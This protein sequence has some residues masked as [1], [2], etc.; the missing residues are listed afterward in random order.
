MLASPLLPSF[1]DTYRPSKSSR[2][3]NT[4]IIIVIICSLLRVFH[5]SVSWWFHTGVWVT[6]TS[7]Q[8][9]MTLLSILADLN[10]A[11]VWMVSTRPV[12]SKYSSPCT[13]SLVTLPR[14][15]ITIGIIV[16]FM[17]HSFFNS[18]AKLRYLSLF[19]HSFIFTLWSAGT[20]KST[21]LHVLFFVVEYYKIWS[22]GQ[23]LVIRLYLKIPEEFVRLIL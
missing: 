4:S 21:I 5:T 11:V 17:F 18:L 13:N 2:V 20:A 15:P 14:A 23:D 10:N 22:S 3:C 19:S 12:I 7:P 8:V 6:K 1:Y 9:S 16:T